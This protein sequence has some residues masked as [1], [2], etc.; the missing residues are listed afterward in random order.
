[1]RDVD[2]PTRGDGG[3]LVEVAP[4]DDVGSL[5]SGE[6][7]AGG[8]NVAGADDGNLD[9]LAGLLE[10]STGDVYQQYNSDTV[11]PFDM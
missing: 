7:I 1:M 11:Q 2:D 3:P 10:H 9:I 8:A 6:T 5:A 4:W